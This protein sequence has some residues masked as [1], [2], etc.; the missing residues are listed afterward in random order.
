MVT[1]QPLSTDERTRLRD[2]LRNNAGGGTLM[3]DRKTTTFLGT[4]EAVEETDETVIDSI[5]QIP[6]HY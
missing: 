6:C 5:R 4:S 2:A 3:M 1:F